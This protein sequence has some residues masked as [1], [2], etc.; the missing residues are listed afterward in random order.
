[1][2][3]VSEVRYTRRNANNSDNYSI[4]RYRQTDSSSDDSWLASEV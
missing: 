4:N 2:Q 3:T 1:M